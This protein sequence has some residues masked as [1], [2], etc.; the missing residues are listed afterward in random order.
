MIPQSDPAG[1]RLIYALGPVDQSVPSGYM[2]IG[3][4]NFSGGVQQS[5]KDIR[6]FAADKGADLVIRSKVFSRM[7]L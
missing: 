3:L 5:E 1:I 2:L 4:V 7:R 6:D